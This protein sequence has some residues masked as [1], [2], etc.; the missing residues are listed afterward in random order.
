MNT[1]TVKLKQGLLLGGKPQLEAV[2]RE[3][4]MGDLREAHENFSDD[5]SAGAEMVRLQIVSIGGIEGPI[6]QA[7]F[8]KIT[9]TDFDRLQ[10]AADELE[11][12]G[13][14]DAEG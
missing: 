2:I 13:R 1:I 4:T 3:S 12:R 8:D 5:S 14:E 11:A 6:T 9:V 7:M 10:K